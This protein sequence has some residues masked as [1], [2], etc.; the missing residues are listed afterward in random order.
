GFML[1]NDARVLSRSGWSMIAAVLLAS[2]LAVLA[3]TRSPPEP[4]NRKV[5]GTAATLAATPG[6][7]AK[8]A[9]TA[10]PLLSS[11]AGPMVDP[12][13]LKALSSLDPNK[14]FMCAACGNVFS[15]EN[16]HVVPIYLDGPLRGKRGDGAYMDSNLC[17]EDA[18]PALA[19]TR[20]RLPQS[21]ND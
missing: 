10:T 4:E 7:T 11:T 6:L 2:L 16:L 9:L 21:S 3:C 8:P 15:R 12:A 1:R 13:Y 17:A 18:K 5:V 19:K 20:A 14:V